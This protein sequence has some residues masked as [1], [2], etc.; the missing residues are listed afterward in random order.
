MMIGGSHHGGG[1]HIPQ[2]LQ[3]I[4]E[5]NLCNARLRHDLKKQAALEP[6]YTRLSAWNVESKSWR[7]FSRKDNNSR[8]PAQTLFSAKEQLHEVH[9]RGESLGRTAPSKRCINPAW[10]ALTQRNKSGIFSAQQANISDTQFSSLYPNPCDQ[11]VLL[12]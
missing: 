11:I 3:K 8:R 9:L 5:A 7:G 4:W 12:F 1:Y 6:F 2:Y 10:A